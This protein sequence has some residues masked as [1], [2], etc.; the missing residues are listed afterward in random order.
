LLKRT[1]PLWHRGLY[2]RRGS[3]DSIDV[4]QGT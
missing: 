4:A 2:Q 1:D 3:W